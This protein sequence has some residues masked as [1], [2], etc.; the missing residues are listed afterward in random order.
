MNNTNS[1]NMDP[2]AY[3][4]WKQQKYKSSRSNQPAGGGG[5]GSSGY[6]YSVNN[7]A[8]FTT[9]NQSG[10]PGGAVGVMNQMQR[11]N[12]NNSIMNSSQ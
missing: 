11:Q 12:S 5:P 3:F 9:N 2:Y 10:A 6:G 8:G 4:K 1:G 7:P